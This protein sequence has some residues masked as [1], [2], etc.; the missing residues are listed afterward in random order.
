MKNA[1][2]K[3]VC[4]MTVLSMCIFLLS[5]CSSETSNN[6][7][8]NAD[9]VSD[10][11]GRSIGET[12]D[13]ELKD[14]LPDID[15]DGETINVVEHDRSDQS[16]IL[17]EIFSE[18]E[19][20]DLIN[21][22][23]YRR[24][25]L[26]EERF[27]IKINTIRNN[28][29]GG[30]VQNAVLANDKSYDVVIGP[31][32]ALR[33]LYTN[34]L[35]LDLNTLPH[36]EFQQPWWDQRATQ[37]F[38]IANKLFINVGASNI[39]ANYYTW[40]VLFNKAL[41]SENAM[42]MPYQSVRDGSWTLDKM[43]NMMKE[44]NP[45]D[46]NGDGAM[47]EH[48]F[49]GMCNEFYNTGAFFVGAG[50]KLFQKNGD[51]IPYL[52]MN[53]QRGIEVLN[54]IFDIVYDKNATISAEDYSGKYG[55][56]WFEVLYPVFMQDRSLFF[57]SG[58]HTIPEIKEMD[59][60]FG[61][62]PM[63]KYDE[64]QKEYYNTMTIHGVM[65]QGVPLTNDKLEATGVFL[66][67]LAFESHKTVVP[68]YYETAMKYKL[69]RDDESIE[70]LEIISKSRIFDLGYIYNWGGALDIYTNLTSSNSRDFVSAYERAAERI[71]RDME[72]GVVAILG[73]EE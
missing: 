22:T 41:V 39:T 36:V 61:I 44:I 47:D 57:V 34:N 5:S 9:I 26:L 65:V 14:N 60:D 11:D 72:R 27:N 1:K 45:R 53:T 7:G 2:K 18:G 40:A 43:Y 49:W 56:P 68:A 6:D 12:L 48:D 59:S 51:D 24:N 54:K 71:L 42:D 46:L 70:M 67:S 16:F 69:L 4:V 23:I 62:L 13:E 30:T 20:G 31:I 8:V 73:L 58:M 17:A 25:L 64:E 28:N 21:D 10:N 66:E 38:S 55:N 3:I 15:F 29:V 33:G 32:I 37:D 19:D 50:E 35:L 52:S 63:P